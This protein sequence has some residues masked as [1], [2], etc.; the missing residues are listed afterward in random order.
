[1]SL[2]KKVIAYLTAFITTALGITGLTMQQRA[3]ALPCRCAHNAEQAQK[4]RDQKRNRSCQICHFVK[5]TVAF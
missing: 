5:P 1:M 4:H 3:E 2:L